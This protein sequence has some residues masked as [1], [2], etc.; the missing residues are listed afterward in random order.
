VVRLST[1][2]TALVFSAA[3]DDI[4]VDSEIIAVVVVAVAFVKFGAIAKDL[5]LHVVCVPG[6]ET[7]GGSF[8]L[9]F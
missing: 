6:V 8:A 2:R 9:R 5:P 3:V 1:Y 7:G 4:A